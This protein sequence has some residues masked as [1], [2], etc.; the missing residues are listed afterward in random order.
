MRVAWP[1]IGGDPFIVKSV[2]RTERFR[3]E[4]KGIQSKVLTA[5]G[6]CES[7]SPIEAASV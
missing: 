1:L 7:G 6:V 3:T 4:T 2:W 5:A